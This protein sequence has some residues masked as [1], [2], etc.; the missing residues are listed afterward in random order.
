MLARDA[1]D[2]KVD[3]LPD[4]GHRAVAVDSR[5]GVPFP[6]DGVDGAGEVAG[7]DVAKQLAA[8]R[9]AT[10]RGP[11]D[12]DGARLKERLERGPH[13]HVVAFGHVLAI[14]VGG[15][16]REPD[17]ELAAL[18]GAGDREAGVAEHVEHRVVLEHDL[19]DELLDPRRGR[20]S[21][22]AARASEF[23]FRAPGTSSP[24]AKATSAARGSRSRTQFATATMR[25]SSDPSSAPRSCQS[26][27]TRGSTS[28]GPSAGKP[29]K[30]R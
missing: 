16:D 30:R 24:T 21:P 1:D 4:L 9:A 28:F 7:E 26:G 5:D 25:P 13:G 23:R 27:A 18:A 2:G 19:R 22:R 15:R 8:D 12:G 17:L 29:W 20:P 3:S 6:V 10:L 14:R 11:D